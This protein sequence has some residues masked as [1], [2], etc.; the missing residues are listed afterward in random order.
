MSKEQLTLSVTGMTCAN[1]AATIERRLN[2]KTPGVINANVNFAIETVSV[3]YLPDETDREKIVESIRFAGYDVIEESSD[4]D[5]EEQISHDKEINNQTNKFLIGLGFALPLFLLSMF[6]DFQLLGDWAYQTWVIWLMW[7]LATP[8]QFY[9]GWDYYVGGYKS[10]R[11][12]SANMDVL[13]ALGSSVAYFYSIIVTFYLS[14]DSTILGNHVYFETSAVIITLIKLGKLIEVR[15]KGK[16]G[17]AIKKLIGLKPKIARVVR[18]NQELDIPLNEVLVGDLIVVRPGE[19]ISVDGVVVDG[20]SS[21]DE[22][23]LTGESIPVDKIKGSKVIGAT[24]NTFGVLKIE[25]KKVGSNT[26]L[27]QIIKSV[28]EAQGSK[29]P[30]QKIADK[31][32]AYFVP[33][34]IVIAFLVFGIW[35]LVDSSF[36]SALLRLIAVLVIA[37]PCAL[38]LATPTAIVVGTGI[39]AAKGILFKNSEALEKVHKLKSIA[40]DKTGTITSGKPKVNEIIVSKNFSAQIKDSNAKNVLLQLAASVENNSEHP[41][42]KAVVDFAKNENLQM[43]QCTDFKAL[44]GNGVVGR[45]ENNQI[46]IGNYDL[47]QDYKKNTSELESEQQR[48][49]ESANTVLWIASGN[50]TIG[51][52]AISDAIKENSANAVSELKK[53]G[54]QVSMITG[55]NESTANDIAKQVGIDKI[56]ARVLPEEKNEVIKQLQSEADGLVGMV[57]D[58]INDAPALAQA[59]VGIAMGSGTDVAIETADITLMGNDLRSVPQVIRLSKATMRTIKQNLFWAFIYNLILIPIAAGILYPFPEAPQFLRSLH[60]V[61]AALAMAFSSVSVVMNS[62]RLKTVKI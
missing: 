54:L 48:L 58:G 7:I 19:K 44:P 20:Q 43:S 22:S 13:V 4:S 62:L 50:D 5:N 9:T 33:I 40:L 41:L 31:V 51:L 52:I 1:C 15:A 61:L 27:A 17:S 55:D 6:R 47:M 29:A 28:Q 30:I 8:V 14:F 18:D 3:E 42:A 23:M 46:L 38:G 36:T 57:G 35:L 24:L 56:F 49:E 11:N 60:P 37:C 21:V 59:D 32:A 34:I 16:T 2:K 45:I 39:G 26:V 10:L 53:I 12:L 25:A